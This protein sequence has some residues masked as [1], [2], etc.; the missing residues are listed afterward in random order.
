MYSV[1]KSYFQ[2][3]VS[4]LDD[5]AALY[6]WDQCF[7]Q[8]WNP[9]VLEDCCLSLLLLLEHKFLAARDY[10]EMKMVLIMRQ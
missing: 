2:A 7:M 6:V 10:T 4:V 5:Q 1:L 3:F 8:R 9:T